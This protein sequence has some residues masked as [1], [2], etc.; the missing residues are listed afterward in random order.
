MIP[1][2]V[3]C[4][5]ET[6]SVRRICARNPASGSKP[7]L[8]KQAWYLEPPGAGSDCDKYWPRYKVE[9]DYG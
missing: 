3:M 6:C 7:K 1:D 9:G 5:S 2:I 4:N 8:E